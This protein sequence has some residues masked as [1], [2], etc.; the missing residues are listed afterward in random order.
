[1]KYMAV[2]CPACGRRIEENLALQMSDEQG[3]LW[4]DS[5]SMVTCLECGAALDVTVREAAAFDV[6]LVQEVVS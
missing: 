2:I 1:M 4:P 5:S 6:A 3:L